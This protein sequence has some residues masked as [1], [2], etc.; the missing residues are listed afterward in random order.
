MKEA[1][2]VKFEVE[3]FPAAIEKIE[4]LSKLTKASKSEV[5]ERLLLDYMPFDEDR[6]LQLLFGDIITR[7]TSLSE[8][9]KR[10]VYLKVIKFVADICK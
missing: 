6:A 8:E 9:A 4:Y 10:S 1:C 5:V 7:T 3:L 2:P